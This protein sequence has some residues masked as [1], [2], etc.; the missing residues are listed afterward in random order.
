L[1]TALKAVSFLK[2][3]IKEIFF[4]VYGDGDFVADFLELREQLGLQCKHP[5][6]SAKL[7]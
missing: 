4:N 5:L 6:F 1:D 3:T 7:N 2:G